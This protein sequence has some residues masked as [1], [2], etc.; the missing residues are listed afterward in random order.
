MLPGADRHSD[1]VSASRVSFVIKWHDYEFCGEGTNIFSAKED[2][3]IHAVS[4]LLDIKLK[5]FIPPS[6]TKLHSEIMRNIR[7]DEVV[8]VK[9]I[10]NSHKKLYK[11]SVKFP[12][13][14]HV[15]KSEGNSIFSSKQKTYS[16]ACKEL[17]NIKKSEIENFNKSSLIQFYHQ[18][19]MDE[20]N[21]GNDTNE[22]EDGKPFQERLLLKW[23]DTVKS[24][25]VKHKKPSL[26]SALIIQ[27]E[28]E[29]LKQKGLCK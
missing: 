22:N 9:S 10:K 1:E 12:S 18:E 7:L 15:V 8:T 4:S 27:S 29:K 20:C 11:T 3:A 17:I 23:D 19:K 13:T 6:K 26:D 5:T 2:A 16:L 25:V 21:E 28:R 14:G 24:Y